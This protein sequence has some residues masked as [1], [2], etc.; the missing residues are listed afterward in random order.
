MGGGGGGGGAYIQ[1]EGSIAGII[2]VSRE[3]VLQHGRGASNWRF[4]V[5]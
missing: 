2:F 3:I 5:S 1:G 4:K